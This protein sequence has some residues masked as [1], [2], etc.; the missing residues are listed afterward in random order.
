MRSK[1]WFYGKASI[2][3]I[4]EDYE[5]KAMILVAKIINGYKES[6]DVFILTSHES[7]VNEYENFIIDNSRL[8]GRIKI[9]N[10]IMIGN[11]EVINNGNEEG[12]NDKRLLFISKFI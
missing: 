4:L 3:K 11:G 2:S 9:I 5:E 12:L 10:K 6:E 1:P 7:N 8:N